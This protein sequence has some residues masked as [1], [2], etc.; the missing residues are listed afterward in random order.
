MALWLFGKGSLNKSALTWDSVTS[1]RLSTGEGLNKKKEMW[2]DVMW[3][4]FHSVEC[5]LTSKTYLS[6]FSWFH[7]IMSF[8]VKSKN[9]KPPEIQLWNCKDYGI[10]NIGELNWDHCT[11]HPFQWRGAGQLGRRQQGVGCSQN[12]I[13][14]PSPAP[15]LFNC[16]AFPLACEHRYTHLQLN[17]AVQKRERWS[18]K[19]PPCLFTR[20]LV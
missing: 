2:D 5:P 20:L 3:C 7:V 17:K 8:S 19:V 12:N 9:K 10:G 6:C 4:V 1:F 11:S 15:L 14:H 18:T 16:N 13:G